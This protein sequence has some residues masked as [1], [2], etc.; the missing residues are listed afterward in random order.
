MRF[1]EGCEDVIANAGEKRELLADLPAIL[2]KATR[3][4]ASVVGTGQVEVALLLAEG[5]DQG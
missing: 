3:L 4:P 1:S 5:A 2:H